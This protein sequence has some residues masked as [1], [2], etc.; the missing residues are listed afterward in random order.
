M[1]LKFTQTC[2]HFFPES[3]HTYNK[4]SLNFKGMVF[5]LTAFLHKKI[6][7]VPTIKNI[8]NTSLSIAFPGHSSPAW[9][10]IL[11]CASVSCFPQPYFWDNHG[12][13]AEESKNN[14]HYKDRHTYPYKYR[15]LPK[16]QDSFQKRKFRI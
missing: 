16:P 15:F 13:T 5:Y 3:N 12:S 7:H 14:F 10:I 9:R 11:R 6:Q 2:S 8:T 4:W 1:N